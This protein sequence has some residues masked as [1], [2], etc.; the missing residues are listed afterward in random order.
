[1][2]NS[3]NKWSNQQFDRLKKNWSHGLP[4]EHPEVIKQRS[5]AQ[6]TLQGWRSAGR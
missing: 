3:I 6:K 4:P 2:R 5:A 1:M